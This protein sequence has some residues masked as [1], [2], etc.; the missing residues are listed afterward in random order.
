MTI[1][2]WFVIF[3]IS[4]SITIP[5]PIYK[6]EE[7]E[8]DLSP[9][10]ICST[11]LPPI[12]STSLSYT[13]D[14][15]GDTSMSRSSSFSS[16]ISRKVRNSFSKI[17]PKVVQRTTKEESFKSHI[18]FDEQWDILRPE[19]E[20]VVKESVKKG[21]PIIPFSFPSFYLADK[22]AESSK[23]LIRTNSVHKRHKDKKNKAHFS[24]DSKDDNP[25]IINKKINQ[26]K[27][28]VER[29][30]SYVE[31]DPY[32]SVC[33][34]SH[35]SSPLGFDDDP[36]M[37]MSG[38]ND[39][40]SDTIFDLEDSILE[41]KQVNKSG[42]LAGNLTT[43]DDSD[44]FKEFVHPMR[45]A[46]RRKGNKHRHDYAFLD[47]EPKVDYYSLQSSKKNGIKHKLLSKLS[48]TR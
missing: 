12:P 37:N 13:S 21:M 20:E 6:R 3:Q 27:T 33:H 22:R 16:Y 36:Y 1:L 39:D 32:H 29:L 5:T 10:L 38:P 19:N 23:H 44:Y 18:P 2:A 34:P 40:A 42:H 43:A 8:E 11:T 30:D 28:K 25:D 26:S 35:A 41:P 17:L 48:T 45:Q 4:A 24:D 31:M 46:V 9:E 14:S 7:D 47:F 15:Y